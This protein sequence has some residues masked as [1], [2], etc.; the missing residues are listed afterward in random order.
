MLCIQ[1]ECFIAA[2]FKVQTLFLADKMQLG[3]QL[4]FN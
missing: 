1:Y 2:M 3:R 4:T